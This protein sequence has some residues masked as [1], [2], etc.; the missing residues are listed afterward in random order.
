MPP[1]IN[2]QSTQ[3]QG[4]EA[5]NYNRDQAK[6]LG[7]DLPGSTYTGPTMATFQNP[8]NTQ[9][10][11]ADRFQ[12]QLYKDANSP[13]DQGAIRQNYINQFQDQ[14]N[15]LNQVYDNQLAQARQEGVGR[16]GSGTAILAR[17]GLAGS[18]RGEAIKEGVLTQNRGIESGIQNERN[19]A[20]QAIY[21]HATQ[22]AAQ[23]AADKRAAKERGASAYLDYLKGQDT[24][25]ADNLTSTVGALIS[26]GIDP[27]T[28][29][30]QEL[31]NLA[32]T[33]G[34]D[35]QNILG[36]YK[37]AKA[38]ADAEQAAAEAKAMQDGQF[39]LSEGQ[40]R[41]D[42]QGNVIASKGKTY[43]PGTGPG[44]SGDNPQ[45]YSGLSS[46]TATAARAKVN[47]FK[48]EPIVTNFATIQEGRN[49]AGSLPND[50]KNPADDQALIYSLAK[51]LDPGS[52]VREG[53][54]AT[55]QKY[56]QS[57]VKAFGSGVS[58]ALL[59]TGFLSQ[60]ARTNIKDT[61]EAR[62][63]ASLKSYDTV[64]SQY[65]NNINSLTGRGDAQNFLVDYTVNSQGGGNNP[66]DPL[67]LF[68]E[69]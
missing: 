54:Y 33:L 47:A 60:E 20:V 41:Y 28:M 27:S 39:N 67:G 42:A 32:K 18:P 29:D 30:A 2:D 38:Q 12:Q 17:R 35:T 22:L 53:E 56:A 8:V 59:G 66:N 57:W 63:Q 48:S 6:K 24:R 14:I 50:T 15:A 36:S 44:V 4:A 25:R 3:A 52:V 11:E 26:Q 49:F 13:I 46:A 43:A 9:Q 7:I 58:Q 1:Q 40:S 51:A 34:V 19:V 61:I 68:G 65:E 62:Y 16:V 55:A 5:V 45:L 37:V 21:G 31:S 64:K 69:Q 23:E 10:T